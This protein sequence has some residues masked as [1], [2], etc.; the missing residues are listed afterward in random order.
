VELPIPLFM[1]QF[2]DHYLRWRGS[3]GELL[4]MHVTLEFRSK[5]LI[6]RAFHGARPFHLVI[7]LPSFFSARFRV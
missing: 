6:N 1:K 3:E 4:N 2:I 7:G 5:V